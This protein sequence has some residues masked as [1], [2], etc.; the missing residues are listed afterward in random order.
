[1]TDIEQVSDDLKFV[2]QV[3]DRRDRAMRTPPGIIYIW[4]TYVLVG[5]ALIDLAPRFSPIFFAVGGCIGG[6]LSGYIGRRE[7]RR[8]GEFDKEIHRRAGMHW[9]IGFIL[10]IA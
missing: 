5:Y 4:A 7:V 2:R 6:M 10:A 3:V 8:S 1:M 9:M